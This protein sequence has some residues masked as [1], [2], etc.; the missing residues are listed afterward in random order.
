MFS[1][2]Q[3]RLTV[4]N[5]VPIFGT[6]AKA[7]VR[8]TEAQR[9]AAQAQYQKAVSQRNL[10]LRPGRLYTRIREPYFFGYVRDQLIRK[11]GAETVRS[12]GLSVYTTIVPRWVVRAT[13][14]IASTLRL[15]D[16]S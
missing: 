13:P 11:Y 12:G 8:V 3:R 16:G 10:K 1:I 9:D 15:G 7:N 5:S 2:T 14:A 6:G 4:V